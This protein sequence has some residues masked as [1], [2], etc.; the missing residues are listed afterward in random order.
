MILVWTNSPFEGWRRHRWYQSH[1]GYNTSRMI[2][3]FKKDLGEDKCRWPHKD[4]SSL[5]MWQAN[6]D[7]LSVFIFYHLLFVTTRVRQGKKVSILPPG[8]VNPEPVASRR[9]LL[10]AVL[11][12]GRAAVHHTM[13][14]DRVPRAS[15][16]LGMSC[17]H[18]CKTWICFCDVCSVV[19]AKLNVWTPLGA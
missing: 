6:M 17:G 4:Y 12:C 15:R 7:L 16:D 14:H 10:E 9:G 1:Y 18:F 11:S 2:L 13:N 5:N 8:D 3:F 19:H